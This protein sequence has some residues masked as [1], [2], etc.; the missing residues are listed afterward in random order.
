MAKPK[1]ALLVNIIAPY[2]LPVYASIAENADFKVFYGGSESNRSS[3]DHSL[4][5][6]GW[7]SKK[8]WGFI[9]KIPRKVNGKV[10]DYR[11]LQITPGFLL[12]L[13]NYRPN[14]IIANEMGFRSLVAL[15]YG[16]VVRKPVSIWWGGTLHTERGVGGFKLKLRKF[17]VRVVKKW[18]SYGQTSTEY[19]LSLGVPRERILQIQ[20]CVDE[21]RFGP[22]LP[23][24][25]PGLAPRPVVL[26][27]GQLINRKGIDQ[28]LR[29]AALVQKRGRE[30]TI[31]IVGSGP[32]E[33]TLK[34]LAEDLELANVQWE[35][36]RKP[37]E[38]PGVYRSADLLVFPTLEDVWG[39]VANEAILSGVPVLCS[40]KAGCA[41][42]I[43]DPEMIFDPENTEDFANHLEAVLLKGLQ[44]ADPSRLKTSVEVGQMIYHWAIQK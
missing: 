30:F 8:S 7:T 27:V 21:S 32:E 31:L 28:L 20:N 37:A 5:G 22:H 4:E 23:A 34:H 44:P 29:A 12:D 24:L 1:L 35:P 26:H 43:A 33:A 16:F 11:Y 19:L 41:P 17:F 2:R 10:F 42:E 40:D 15:F 14:A 38:M 6:A 25:W 36:A 39:L 9:L 13:I 18:I 3:W